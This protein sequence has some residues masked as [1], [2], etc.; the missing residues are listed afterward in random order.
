MDEREKQA[1]QSRIRVMAKKY[2]E[3][4]AYDPTSPIALAHR[5]EVYKLMGSLEMDDQFEFADIFR[6]ESMNT[7]KPNPDTGYGVVREAFCNNLIEKMRI[8]ADKQYEGWQQIIRDCMD[9]VSDDQFDV[10]FN[11]INNRKVPA[12]INGVA[13]DSRQ[14]ERYKESFKRLEVLVSVAKTSREADGMS[15]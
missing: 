9:N 2:Q 15:M 12:Q 3:V 13:L 11:S 8:A 14:Q 4:I 7:N 1:I 5:Q 6:E 10:L